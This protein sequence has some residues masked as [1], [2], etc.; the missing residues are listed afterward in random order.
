[1][2]EVSKGQVHIVVYIK[3]LNIFIHLHI[4]MAGFPLRQQL[5]SSLNQLHLH[6]LNPREERPR[7]ISVTTQLPTHVCSLSEKFL[8]RASLA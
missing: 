3:A 2:K 4:I 5:V 8:Q 6:S 7:G 1:M